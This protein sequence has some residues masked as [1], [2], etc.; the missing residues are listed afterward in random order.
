MGRVSW[1]QPRD[2][3][4]AKALQDGRSGAGTVFK[5]SFKVMKMAWEGVQA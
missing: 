4:K 3:F 1:A 2:Q 5:T